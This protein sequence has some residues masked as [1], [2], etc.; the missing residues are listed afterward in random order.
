MCLNAFTNSIQYLLR[1]V[2]V[3]WLG[4]RNRNGIELLEAASPTILENLTLMVPAQIKV[5]NLAG[6]TDI[7]SSSD[8][9][10]YFYTLLVV[11]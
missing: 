11:A 5:K 3:C 4:D 2:S 6:E 8:F 1:I 7:L 10:F 9:L